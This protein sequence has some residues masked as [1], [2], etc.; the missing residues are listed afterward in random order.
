VNETFLLVLT[1]ASLSIGTIVE[2]IGLLVE[3]IF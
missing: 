2:S 3:S 1:I